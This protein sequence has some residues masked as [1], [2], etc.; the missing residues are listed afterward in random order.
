MILHLLKMIWNRKRTNRLIFLEIFLSFIVLFSVIATSVYY[1]SNY[2]LPLG[3]SCRDVWVIRADPKPYIGE[4]YVQADPGLQEK[5][6]QVLLAIRGLNEVEGI[7]A[8]VDVPYDVRKWTQ[9]FLGTRQFT[10]RVNEVSDGYKEVMNLQVVHGRWFEPA[11]DS[12]NWNPVVVNEKFARMAFGEQNPVGVDI[13]DT[14]RMRIVGVISEFRKDGE[15]STPKPYVLFRRS[16]EKP[17]PDILRTMVIKVKP[18]TARSFEEQL[19]N[20]LNGVAKG[21][22]FEVRPLEEIREGSLKATVLSVKILAIIDMFLMIMVVLGLFGVL[23]QNVTQ[24]TMEI[25]LRRAQGATT[26]DIYWQIMGELFFIATLGIIPGILLIVQFPL[27]SLIG[28]LKTSIY[29]YSIAI[30]MLLIYLMTFICGLYPG[31][32]A[33]RVRPA[34]ALHYE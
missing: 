14:P 11:D 9:S 29:F 20:V 16:L 26:A 5:Y 31:W 2:R 8:A 12:L 6:R 28:D 17:A 19:M 4:V 13:S 3:F 10:S 7:A 15:Y 33:T 1:L 27:L 32:L 22:A 18:G 30:S 34:D 25:G 21:W 24:R 23:W